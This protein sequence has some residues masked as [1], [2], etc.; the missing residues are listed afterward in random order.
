[1]RYLVYTNNTY[2]HHFYLIVGYLGIPVVYT[3]TCYE[4]SGSCLY[5]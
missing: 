3:D 4:Y 2:D 5:K 1:M